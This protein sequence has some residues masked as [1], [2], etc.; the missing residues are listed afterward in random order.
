MDKLNPTTVI[1]YSYMIAF[2]VFIVAGLVSSNIFFLLLGLYY[3]LNWCIVTR[4]CTVFITATCSY[5]PYPAVCR[6]VGVSWMHGIGRIRCNFRR[7][8]LFAHFT[9]NLKLKRYFLYSSNTNLHL[10]YALSLKVIYEI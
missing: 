5:V 4:W 2:I 10:I 8:L 6:A 1:K 9:F 3:L 7:L